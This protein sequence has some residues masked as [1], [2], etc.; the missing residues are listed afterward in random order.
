MHWIHRPYWFAER[1][2]T[3]GAEYAVSEKLQLPKHWYT[4]TDMNA[5][6]LPGQDILQGLPVDMD[7]SLLTHPFQ[8][9][10]RKLL[11]QV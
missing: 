3:L 1:W 2:F 10:E 7:A 6:L 8:S 4:D 5:D 11:Q 9:E